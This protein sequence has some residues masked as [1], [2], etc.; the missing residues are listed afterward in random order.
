MLNEEYQVEVL[1]LLKEISLNIQYTNVYL[2]CLLV[3]IGVILILLLM[4]RFLKIFI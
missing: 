4:Y 2:F 1:K 3:G